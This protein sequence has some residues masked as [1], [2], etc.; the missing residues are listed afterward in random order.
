MSNAKTSNLIQ[1]KRD[2]A[3][4]YSRLAVNTKSRA[5][6]ISFS[7]RAE[8]YRRQAIQLERD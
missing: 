8:R 5:K 1:V 6:R 2:L 7:S 4:K 3:A